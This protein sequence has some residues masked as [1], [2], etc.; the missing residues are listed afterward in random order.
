MTG[1]VSGAGENGLCVAEL[2]TLPFRVA[3]V[4]YFWKPVCPLLK[5]V[6]PE[7]AS[8]VL[9]R[10]PF[11]LSSVLPVLFPVVPRIL[12]GPSLVECSGRLCVC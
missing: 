2:G 6:L 1:F 3:L 8:V 11:E 9:C 4:S 7:Y 12:F 5:P 10:V